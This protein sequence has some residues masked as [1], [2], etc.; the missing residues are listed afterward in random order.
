M[1]NQTCEA[2]VDKSSG[3]YNLVFLKTLSKSKEQARGEM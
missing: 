3:N 1:Q 2:F